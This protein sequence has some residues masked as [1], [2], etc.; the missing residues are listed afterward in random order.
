MSPPGP[1]C[2]AELRLD[3]LRGNLAVLRAACPTDTAVV[4]VIKADAYGHGAVP[5][6]RVLRDEGVGRFGVATL[7]EAAELRD[8]GF[9]EP[10][11]HLGLLA[12][13]EAAAAVALELVPTITEADTLAALDRAARGRA[14]YPVHL[15]L[16]T[17]MGR[18][19]VTLDELRA[20]WRAVEESD[21]LSVDGLLTHFATADVDPAFMAE[22]V[23]A[24]R[25]ARQALAEEGR[26]AR[27]YHLAN[28][29]AILRAG[30]CGGNAVRPGLNLYGPCAGDLPGLDRLQ[31]M[32]SLH[33][34]LLQIRSLPAGHEVGYAHACRLARPT[35]V[36]LASIGYGDGWPWQLSNGAEALVG[37]LRV[38]YLGRVNMDMIQLDLNSVP[39]A[40]V[41]D[42]V[43]LLGRDGAAEI[44][45]AEVARWAACSEYAVCT[46]L[47]RRVTR[48]WWDGDRAVAR[49]GHD[50]LVRWENGA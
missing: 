18:R 47:G 37:G 40:R 20:L 35:R 17:G 4:G 3:A 14:P 50:G 29:A 9:T 21:A 45:R 26:T 46:Q 43:T 49:R 27:W 39:A 12:P 36:G 2:W 32:M 34:R 19:G 44:T 23:E 16:D 7:D 11:W 24:F 22:Q 33:A 25:R 38:P 15:K 10:L 1:R 6:A 13:D 42:R 31:P 48:R 30:A 41:G 28:S 5:C 8:A